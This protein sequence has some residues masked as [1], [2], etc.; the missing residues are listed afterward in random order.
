MYKYK[1]RL[2][3]FVLYKLILYSKQLKIYNIPIKYLDTVTEY[4]CS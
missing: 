2:G 4:N 3:H 1:L